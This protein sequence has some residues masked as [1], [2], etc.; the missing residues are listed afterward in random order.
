M[1]YFINQ[2]ECFIRPSKHEEI[3]ES[4]SQ[5]PYVFIIFELC[6]GKSSVKEIA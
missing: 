4:T 3:D 6:D 1:K 5:R 2:G